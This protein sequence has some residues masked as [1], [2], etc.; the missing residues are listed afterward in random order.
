MITHEA[1]FIL[2]IMTITIAVILHYTFTVPLERALDEIEH[3][4][5]TIL[6]K[7]EDEGE[8]ETANQV[9]DIIEERG[10]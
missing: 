5:L 10:L 1:A 9:L 7:S 2:F 8:R 3:A 4:C 6:D